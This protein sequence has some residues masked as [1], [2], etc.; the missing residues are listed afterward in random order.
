[1]QLLA[2]ATPLR[3]CSHGLI[4]GAEGYL[5]SDAQFG[6]EVCDGINSIRLAHAENTSVLLV[7][8]LVPVPTTCKKDES[9][10]QQ[11][12]AP[13][14]CQHKSERRQQRY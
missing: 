14:R 8:L 12:N 3:P 1:M 11:I 5:Q 4:S 2:E 6:K 13:R 10:F 9:H 7:L